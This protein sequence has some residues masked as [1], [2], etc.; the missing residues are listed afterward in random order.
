MDQ[1]VAHIE[2]IFYYHI[3][4]ALVLRFCNGLSHMYICVKLNGQWRTWQWKLLITYY[5]IVY[6]VLT[7]LKNQLCAIQIHQNALSY[8]M[9]NILY[10]IFEVIQRDSFLVWTCHIHFEVAQLNNRKTFLRCV[11]VCSCVCDDKKWQW[12]IFQ[13]HL[14][15]YITWKCSMKKYISCDCLADGWQ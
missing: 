8:V 1:E 13:P 14:S 15:P 4:Q 11:C 6:V 12:T 2:Y 10:E 7:W 9:C 3:I 5:Y